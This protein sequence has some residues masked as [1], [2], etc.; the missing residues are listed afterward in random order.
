MKLIKNILKK[1][2]ARNT[3]ITFLLMTVATIIS[4]VLFYTPNFSP[5]V[6]APIYILVLILIGTY[7]TGYLPGI[8][9]SVISVICINF[10]FTYPYFRG[11]IYLCTGAL[12]LAAPLGHQRW[13]RLS[14]IRSRSAAHL[15][16][17]ERIP[18]RHACRIPERYRH[19]L[20]LHLSLLGIQ[21]HNDRL[22]ADVFRHAVRIAHHLHDDHQDQAAGAVPHGE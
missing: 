22:S 19:Q 13:L 18:V 5:S 2:F 16:L 21:L 9:A 1:D 20:H 10:L 12:H 15:A 7:T 17:H 11:D 14:G 8:I 6:I 4:F 3:I